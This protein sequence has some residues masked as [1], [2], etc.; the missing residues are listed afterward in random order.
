VSLVREIKEKNK[1]WELMKKD[2]CAYLYLIGDLDPFY[3]PKTRW[4]TIKGLPSVFLLYQAEKHSILITPKIQDSSTLSEILSELSFVLPERFYLDSPA[5]PKADRN[6]TI[7]FSHPH[8][9][10]LLQNPSLKRRNP[11]LLIQSLNHSHSQQLLDF[12]TLSYPDHWYDSF[13]I[14]TGKFKAII[15]DDQILSVAGIH[16]YS[17]DYKT[18]AL[19]NIAT[20]PLHR[21]QGYGYEV[22]TA[23]CLELM[24]ECQWI[25]LN[26]L[27]KNKKAIDLYHQIGFKDQFTFYESEI[28]KK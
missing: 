26:V 7:G 1:L 2:P 14:E 27:S 25:G 8:Q 16:T 4:F 12:Y 11:S 3:F 28:T 18:A 13:M 19:G 17:P 6:F 15:K 23:L 22:I 5:R 24:N 10:M 9:R 20:H 21:N